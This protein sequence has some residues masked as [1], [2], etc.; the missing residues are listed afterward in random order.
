MNLWRA[1]IDPIENTVCIIRASGL[2]AALIWAS[3]AVRAAM[4]LHPHLRAIAESGGTIVTT[5][6]AALSAKRW[7]QTRPPPS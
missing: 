6:G 7:S 1:L 2:A 3:A 4:G 5:L